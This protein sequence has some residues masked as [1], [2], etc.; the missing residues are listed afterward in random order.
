MAYNFTYD[1]FRKAAESSGLLGE[2][3]QAD[4]NLAQ[5]NPDAGMSLLKY[6]QDWHSATTDEARALANQGAESIRSSY[7][8][9]TGGGNGG[10]FHLDGLSPGSFTPSTAR[11]EYNNRYDDTIQDL[12]DQIVNREDFT[13]DPETD[14]LYGQYRK[15]YTREG[16]RATQDALGAA[17]AASGG[18]PSSYAATAAAQAGNYYAAQMS[19]KMPE[20]YELAYNQY[21]NDYNM[22]LNDLGAVQGA[23]QRDYDKYLDALGQ[24]NTDRAFDYGQMLD[25]I[26][27]QTLERQEALNNALTA[28][29]FGDYSLLQGMGIDT[30]NNPTDWE[31][32][33]QLALLGAQYGDFS[34]LEAL[35]LKPDSKTMLDFALASAGRTQ[36]VG[37]ASG[38]SGG[39][40][41]GAGGGDSTNAYQTLRSAGVT[42]M[43]EAYLELLGMGYS[44]TEAENLAD[45]YLSWLE[46][47]SSAENGEEVGLGDM[48]IA[49]VMGLGIGPVSFETLDKLTEDGKVELYTNG[50]GKTAVRWAEGYNQNNYKSSGWNMPD[51]ISMPQNQNPFKQ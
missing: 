7:G 22:K 2:F 32:K 16:Q 38:G 35:G 37:S 45:Y 20:L 46:D 14:P 1:E 33:Y 26:N 51:K 13:Y 10:S 29:E 42:T 5:R 12:L 4:L 27:S 39:G 19:D 6:K 48:D 30:S 40:S 43:G 49:S 34:G 11:P 28:A 23:E 3:S 24:W 18:M 8:N 21:L 25:E 44:S 31:R 15:Q 17:A 36:P 41:G 47:S 50:S 9:Y